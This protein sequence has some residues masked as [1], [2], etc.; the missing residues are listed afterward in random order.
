MDELLREYEEIRLTKNAI[1]AL[2]LIAQK[3]KTGP[4]EF[5]KE[6]HVVNPKEA[7][8]A[9]KILKKAKFVKPS[10]GRMK[11]YSLTPL[12]IKFL[13]SH[14]D[15]RSLKIENPS[16]VKAKKIWSSLSLRK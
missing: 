3:G 9:F 8:T 10:K 16:E 14:I 2:I 13:E 15:V 4:Y 7:Y 1:K 11:E 12:G 5:Y 6:K